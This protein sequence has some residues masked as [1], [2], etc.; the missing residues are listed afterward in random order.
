MNKTIVLNKMTNINWIKIEIGLEKYNEIMTLYACSSNLSKDY[1][2]QK[3][4]KAFY[5]LNFAKKS[6][7]FYKVYF[8][9]LNK[10]SKSGN[11]DIDKVLKYLH[12]VEEKKELS[13]ASKMLATIDPN[14]PVWD[15][16]VRNVLK[17][18]YKTNF[19]ATYKD[20]IECVEAYKVFCN[21]YKLFLKTPEAN[22]FIAEFDKHFPKSKIS[23]M[24]KLD[25]IFWQMEV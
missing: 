10:I 5:K 15:S 21:W 12:K 4:Y 11:S 19:K 2:F 3:K 6:D 20:I 18:K 16:K 14:L 7:D 22:S 9:L 1:L 24:K 25:F 23:K 17:V 13:F 8:M